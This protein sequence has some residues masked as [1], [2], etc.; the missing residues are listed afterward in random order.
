MKQK[1]G[2]P[3]AR[4][5]IECARTATMRLV[6]AEDREQQVSALVACLEIA[7]FRKSMHFWPV[8]GRT[9]ETFVA[10]FS[11]A[12]NA[13]GMEIQN[14][15]WLEAGKKRGWKIQ[16]VGPIPEMEMR[17]MSDEEIADEVLAIEIEM[18]RMWLL[19]NKEPAAE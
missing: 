14:R 6:R 16:A 15:I 5:L 7:R 1:S 9:A 12:A 13:L 2:E 4:E 18:W 19:E 17:G 8:N 10:G 11:I 3:Q